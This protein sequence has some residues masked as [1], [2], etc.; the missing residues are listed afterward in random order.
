MTREKTSQAK[1]QELL[2]SESTLSRYICPEVTDALSS[3][4]ADIFWAKVD[5]FLAKNPATT[6]S[7]FVTVLIHSINN[8][9]AT[10]KSGDVSTW[11]ESNRLEK[12]AMIQAALNAGSA[13]ESLLREIPEP[14]SSEKAL[15]TNQFGII[16]PDAL[17]EL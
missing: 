14:N 2:Q 4:S 7:F 8:A 16:S 12:Q 1:F 9:L 6:W 15:Y 5:L 17:I 10:T 13:Y 3:P 11:Y